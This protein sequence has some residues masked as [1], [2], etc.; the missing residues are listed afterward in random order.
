LVTLRPHP[1]H[2]ILP[3][4]LS[5]QPSLP[6]LPPEI[7]LRVDKALLLAERLRNSPI[8]RASALDFFAE[9][10]T[11]GDRD[12]GVQEAITSGNNFLLMRLHGI[13]R[14]SLS[15]TVVWWN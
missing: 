8:D 13:S 9:A 14:R 15:A 1:V 5:K 6:V 2:S 12:F 11:V 3:S 10:Y 7:A 4:Q